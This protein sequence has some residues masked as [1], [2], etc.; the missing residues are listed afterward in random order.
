MSNKLLLASFAG[1]L[2]L[3]ITAFFLFQSNN[4]LNV[5]TG[6]Q[7]A[8]LA[9]TTDNVEMYKTRE[10]QCVAATKELVRQHTV[11]IQT[12]KSMADANVT[13]NR[14]KLDRLLMDRGRIE[15]VL[16]TIRQPSKAPDAQGRLDAIN[17]M[18]DAYI[19]ELKK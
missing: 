18:V 3:C 5:K 15:S 8:T 1:N 16:R 9:A 19:E 12:L 14:A 17:R 11:E 13:R 4:V 10:T 2:L 6:E 7:A